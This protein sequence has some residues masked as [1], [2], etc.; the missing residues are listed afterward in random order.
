LSDLESSFGDGDIVTPEALVS[1]GLIRRADEPYKVLATGSIG[2]ALV[3]RAPRSSRAAQAAIEAAG[4]SVE[5]VEG[6][7]RRAGM[8]RGHRRQH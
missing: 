1:V 8:G 5:T 7:Y 6:Q 3:V 4:G 2:K